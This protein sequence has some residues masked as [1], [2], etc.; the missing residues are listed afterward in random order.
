MQTKCDSATKNLVEAG[1][2]ILGREPAPLGEALGRVLGPD[3]IELVLGASGTAARHGNEDYCWS[4]TT[5]P[6]CGAPE[7]RGRG[8]ATAGHAGLSD[9]A[10][11]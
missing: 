4:S 1:H 7:P 10:L 6:S 2:D 8:V 3:G 11:R 5:A 9:R